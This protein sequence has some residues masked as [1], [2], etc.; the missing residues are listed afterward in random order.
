MDFEWDEAKRHSNL[1][2]HGIDFRRARQI[3]DGRPRLDTASPR[4]DEHRIVTVAISNETF[5]AVAWTLRSGDRI[6]II[7]ARRARREEERQYRQVHG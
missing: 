7:S 6:R 4:G 2:K 5:I 1:E 3:F